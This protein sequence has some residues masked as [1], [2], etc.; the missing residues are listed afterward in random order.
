VNIFPLLISPV[1]VPVVGTFYR[2]VGP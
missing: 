2:V 1:C